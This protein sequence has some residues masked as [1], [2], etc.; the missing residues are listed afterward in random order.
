MHLKVDPESLVEVAGEL[1]RTATRVGGSVEM[2]AHGSRTLRSQWTGAAS[3]AF[4]ARSAALDADARQH[5]ADLRTT[6]EVVHR[7]AG[8]YQQADSDGA[9]AVIGI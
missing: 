8:E 3:S 6:A 4:G 2:L 1:A 7:I 5:V 9:R